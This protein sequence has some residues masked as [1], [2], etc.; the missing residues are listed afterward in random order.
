MKQEELEELVV[1][2][3]W[4][5]DFWETN[6]FYNLLVFNAEGECLARQTIAK[7]KNNP[8]GLDTAAEY[9]AEQALEKLNK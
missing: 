5:V 7:V 8:M 1:A 4:E 2:N 9:L 6:A 3:D